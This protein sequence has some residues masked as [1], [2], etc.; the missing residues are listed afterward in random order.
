MVPIYE[1]YA[2]PHAYEKLEIAGRDITSFLQNLLIAKYRKLTGSTGFEITKNLKEQLCY[3]ALNYTK[4]LDITTNQTKDFTLP[5]GQIISIGQERFQAPECL[6]KPDLLGRENNTGVQ[7]K[8]F[9]SIQKCDM[10]LR[11]NVCS[12]IVLSGGSSLFAGF[13]QR[14]LEEI[15]NLAPIQAQIIAPPERK[16]RVD[17]LN[18]KGV[19][20]Y[21]NFFKFG[22][23]DWIFF[24][25]TCIQ[26]ISLGG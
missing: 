7:F 18:N 14:L 26:L 25:I 10:D 23:S 15:S 6:F 20:Q 2:L 16:Y 5:D 9:D 13:S 12:N 1:G 3:V 24:L 21:S 4:E 19:H 8:I 11:E 17:C 22:I